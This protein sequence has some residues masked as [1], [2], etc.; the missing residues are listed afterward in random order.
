MNE[1]PTSK[2]IMRSLFL[3]LS[4]CIVSGF[5]YASAQVEYT[6][7][8]GDTFA[9]I[10]RAHDVTLTELWEANPGRGEALLPGEVVRIPQPMKLVSVLDVADS[11]PVVHTVEAGQTLYAIADIYGIEVAQLET[12][13]P[14]A[15]QGLSIGDVLVVG[16]LSQEK[17]V[18][19]ESLGVPVLT[20]QSLPVLR[21]DTLRTLL[22]LPFMLE[23]DTVDGGGYSAKTNRLREIALE[24]MHG[25]QWATRLL[26]DSGY[27]VALRLVDTEPDSLGVHLWSMADL[28]WADVVLG[29]LRK[30]PLDSV[31][32]LLQNSVVP[33]WVLT[34]QNPAIWEKH[35][36][37]FSMEPNPA[38]GMQRLG[39][40][41]AQ[42][43]AGDTV[44]MLET[45]GADIAL[46]RAFR[47]GFLST[48]ADSTVL[49]SV[50][51]NTQF[52]EGLIAELDTSKLNPIAIPAGK[53]AQSLYAYVQTELQ[54]ADSF[55]V[56]VY[57][58]P[59]SRSFGFLERRYLDRSHYTLPISKLTRW[60]DS[61]VAGQMKQFRAAH[62]TDPSV[63]GLIAFDAMIESA[64]WQGLP[65]PLPAQVYF[66]LN[67]QWNE[68]RSRF[69]NEHWS[70][71]T[72]VNGGW[73][74][75]R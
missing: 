19:L 22:M 17:P 37:A 9:R 36:L 42:Q 10:A 61:E 13:N 25:A 40:L 7:L 73:E 48:A 56:H 51:A 44:I 70:L 43:H 46:E 35:P 39:A 75:V 5:Q 12:W 66:T 29:P 65:W 33:Q 60:S 8:P 63:Y 54:L 27:A 20:D 68:T 23:A 72:F 24:F 11:E 34:P 64:R 55:P 71:E 1:P 31:N 57:G 49:Q 52:S 2:L 59:D 28:E 26:S 67:W 18:N 4:L 47:R 21:Q 41:A 38:P 69:I 16:A 32:S 53:S 50:P 30:E 3:V 62:A 6:A 58:H 15:V 14:T 74:P 45:R